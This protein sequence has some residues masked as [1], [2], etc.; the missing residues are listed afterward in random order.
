MTA[1]FVHG[2]PE[3]AA[4]WDPLLAELGRDDVVRLSPPGFGAPLPPGFDATVGA[5]RAWLTAEL[6]VIG[7]PV[8][9]VGHDWGG[10][11]VVGIAMTRPDLLRSWVS[12]TVGSYEPDYVWH[13]L[14][15][16]W[17]T[18]GAGEEAVAKDFASPATIRARLES[19]GIP[20]A[21]AGR[22]AD[23]HHFD[24]IGRAV[25]ALY[26]SAA[27]PVMA[28]LGANLPAAAQRPGLV[29]IAGADVAVGS[30][31]QRRR[32]AA[33]AGARVAELPGLGHWW[34]VEDPAAGARAI[35][36]FWRSLRP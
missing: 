36:E 6:E 32:G 7:E 8:D 4:V 25:L 5:Y 29:V 9:L 19:R 13:E 10:S 24:D 30:P 34:L 16:V 18:P 15:A 33:R 1:V 26:R 20:T 11:H 27:Q 22:V 12:D 28:E 14:A 35:S 21:L 2:N 31:E 17:Q 3:T 23:G